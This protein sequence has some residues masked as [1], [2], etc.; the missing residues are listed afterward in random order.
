MTICYGIAYKNINKSCISKFTKPLA[1]PM[2]WQTHLRVF[3]VVLCKSN[4]YK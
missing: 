3:C 4:R 1:N 2:V